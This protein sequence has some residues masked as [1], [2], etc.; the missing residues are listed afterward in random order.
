MRSILTKDYWKRVRGDAG[1]VEIIILFGVPL[2]VTYDGR[3]TYEARI[4]E[5]PSSDS[6]FQVPAG[7]KRLDN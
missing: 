5:S 4:V 3:N 6:P 7:Y 1:L 2:R